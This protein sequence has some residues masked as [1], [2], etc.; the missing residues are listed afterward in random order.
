[1]SRLTT[2]AVN[3]R[4][5]QPHPL[6]TEEAPCARF[7]TNERIYDA[8][9]SVHEIRTVSRGDC[10]MWTA[11][12]AA[13]RLSF[14]GM[15]LPVVRRR[16]SSP[17]QAR[18]H[19]AGQTMETGPTPKSNQRSRAFRFLPFGRIR[20]PNRSS[21]RMTGSTAISGSQRIGR[22]GVDGH[23][24]VLLRTS[25][26][27]VDGALVLPSCTPDEAIVATIETLDVELLSR[28]DTVHLPEL[29]REND[30]ALRGDGGLHI[31]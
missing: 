26:Q 18:V 14:I 29:C 31:G 7:S 12:V 24:E 28:F 4:L 8:H 27:P 19:V 25:E 17:F 3:P 5:P 11:T 6:A 21:P 9:A 20:I 16:A 30:L 2:T 1:M 13:I 10:Q 22:L 15:A 23:E